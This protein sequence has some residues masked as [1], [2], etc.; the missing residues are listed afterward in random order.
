[1]STWDVQQRVSALVASCRSLTWSRR[2]LSFSQGATRCCRCCAGTYQDQTS[3]THCLSCDERRFLSAVL[4][5]V[6]DFDAATLLQIPAR[7][8]LTLLLAQ[9][10][11]INVKVRRSVGSPITPPARTLVTT[12]VKT[13]AVSI[14]FIV[15][16]A[17]RLLTFIR[18]TSLQPPSKETAAPTLI[19]ALLIG[20][21][22]DSSVLRARRSALFSTESVAMNALIP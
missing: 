7:T 2:R 13:I 4:N 22:M 8:S 14:P 19:L 17:H 3:Q 1:M 10:T 21:G 9:A 12:T 20:G 18:F 5:P 15:S 16:F 6:Q 11:L